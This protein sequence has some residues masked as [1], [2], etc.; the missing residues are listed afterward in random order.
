MRETI[1]DSDPC[2]PASHVNVIRAISK[3]L[4]ISPPRPSI[5][6]ELPLCSRGASF[7]PLKTVEVCLCVCVSARF[8]VWRARA[9]VRA[10]GGRL[11]ATLESGGESSL[12][13]YRAEPAGPPREGERQGVTADDSDGCAKFCRQLGQLDTLTTGTCF[14]PV[15][16]Y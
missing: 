10:Y 7:C 15:Q 9:C 13:C 5:I 8:S 2:V 3:S 4:Q 6:L 11:H 1:V 12:I 14:P 16:I